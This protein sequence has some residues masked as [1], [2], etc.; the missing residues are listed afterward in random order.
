MRR[1]PVNRPPSEA[2]MRLGVFLTRHARGHAGLFEI[3]LLT[4]AAV[5]ADAPRSGGGG[6]RNLR[7]RIHTKL[8]FNL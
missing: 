5:V 7:R 3:V 4:E 6:H 2:M 1:Q 8:C